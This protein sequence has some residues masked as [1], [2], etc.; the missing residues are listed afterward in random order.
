[1]VRHVGQ[2]DIKH[3]DRREDQHTEHGDEVRLNFLERLNRSGALIIPALVA[4]QDMTEH[5]RDNGEKHDA[6]IHQH[7]PD[8]LV[9]NPAEQGGH[10]LKVTRYAH[11]PDP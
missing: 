7:R 1:M 6:S 11:R 10:K 3:G 5:Q 4:L 2:L 9:Q 8:T